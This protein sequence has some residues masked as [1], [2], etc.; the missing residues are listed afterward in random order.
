M[1]IQKAFVVIVIF[2]VLGIAYNSLVVIPREKLAQQESAR[3][4]SE[5]KEFMRSLNYDACV[6]EALRVYS[7]NWDGTCEL[8]SKERD[9]SLPAFRAEK[10]E[11]KL[12]EEKDRCVQLYK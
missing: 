4:A 10:H 3:R 5:Q 11:E 9:C 6:N 7:S 12:S 1:K 8:L 2:A